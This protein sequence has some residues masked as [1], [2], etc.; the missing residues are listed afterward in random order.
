MVCPLQILSRNPRHRF[1][2]LP[3]PALK[4]IPPCPENAKIPLSLF[5]PCARPASPHAP[6][7]TFP[8]PNS[9]TF[10][11]L[12][13][14][15]LISLALYAPTL[16]NGFVTDDNVQILQ[17]PM[18]LDGK[19]LGQAF[20]TDAWAFA[21]RTDEN[22]RSTSNYYRPLQPLVYFAE[23]RLFGPNPVGWH[24]VNILL[25]AAVVAA[26]YLLFS[27]LATAPLAFW[28]ALFFALHPVHAEPVA[29]IAA[30]PELQCALFLLLAML[31][32]HRSR[33]A[34]SSLPTFLLSV[35]FFLAA[36]FSKEP[37]ILFPAILLCYELL[38]PRTHPL[39]LRSIASRLSPFLLALLVYLV[40]R[41]SALGAFSPLPNMDRAPLSPIQLFLAIPAVFARYVGKLLLPTHLNYFYDFPLTT[42]FTVWALEG[43]LLSFLFLPA[44][45]YFRKNHA[46]LSFALCWFAFMLAPA[47][48]LNSV[49]I[50][51]FTERYLYIPSLGFSIL[52]A[53]LILAIY[54]RARASSLRVALGVA[55]VALFA[56]YIVQTQRRIAIFH[57]NLSLLSDTVRNSP[58][59]Y[60]VQGQLGYAYYERGD[61]DRALEHVLLALQINPAYEVGHINAAWY[62]TDKGNYDAAILHLKEAI[63][64][65]PEFL[66]PWVNLAKVYTLQR[67]WPH[68]RETLDHAATVNPAKSA[69][70]Q[71]LAA[72]AAANEKSESALASLQSATSR[73]PRDFA[74]WVQLGD[75]SSQAGQWPRAAEAYEHAATLQP[76]NATVLDKWG[77]SLLRTG[78]ASRAIEILQ[79]AVEAQPDSLY[80]RQ[81]LA[82]ALASS[83]RLAESTAQFQN[84]L[85]MN[86]KWEHADQ[87]HLALGLNAEKFGDPAA[88]AREYQRALD[89]NPSLTLARQHLLA[90]SPTAHP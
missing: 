63:R 32:Y 78:D 26:I 23:Y 1:S 8:P 51:F 15:I 71:Q 54:Q 21:L 29:W 36:L 79:R 11:H 81:G 2:F 40:A 74:C 17:N 55:L 89:L 87:V 86:P 67:D 37:A 31:F 66:Q 39:A 64:L 9:G 5:C 69:H 80:I 50:N 38:F 53:S 58:R 77:I 13:I 60:S 56:F 20:T 62:L 76:A 45:F 49:A 41:I 22:S 59:S 14:L 48:S 52:A 61:V 3:N 27:S 84:I 35:V 28:V 70:F 65:H 25:N 7:Q 34:M 18:V 47:L 16:R 44:F 19:E 43:F 10:L 68:A 73:D 83:N 42:S 72:V 46:V 82:S 24:L 30:L 12:A 4:S 75:T 57:D 85:Q 6:A 88:A 33:S 90:L